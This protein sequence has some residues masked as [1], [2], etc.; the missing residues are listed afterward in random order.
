MPLSCPSVSTSRTSL[1]GRLAVVALLLGAAVLAMPEA[2]FADRGHRHPGIHGSKFGHGHNH[3]GPR[4]SIHLSAPA[5]RPHHY[6]APP[7]AYYAPPVYHA[8]RVFHVPPVVYA[9]PVFYAP[10][11]YPAPVIVERAPTVYVERNDITS[12]P[13]PVEAAP[14]AEPSWFFCTDSNTYYPYVT[15]CASPWERVR[16]AP[17]TAG[18]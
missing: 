1:Q 13:P 16:P 8:P 11:V 12:A 4:V 10:R 18:R 14:A 7:R 15:Q 9:P 17:P 6:Y 2:A 3:G 5:Y